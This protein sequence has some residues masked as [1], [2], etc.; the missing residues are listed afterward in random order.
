MPEHSVGG[1]TIVVS[2]RSR[3]FFFYR[4]QG[5]SIE[6]SPERHWWCLWLCSSTTSIDLIQCAINLSGLAPDADANGQCSDCGSLNVMGPAFW[7]FNIPQPFQRVTYS[8]IV[9]INGERFPISGSIV[10]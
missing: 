5:V 7:G 2:P 6:V 3:N 4:S 9:Q 8:G 1:E 10:L